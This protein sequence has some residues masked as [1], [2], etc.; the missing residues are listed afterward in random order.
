MESCIYLVVYIHFN[1]IYRYL[2]TE[3]LTCVLF[4]P[5]VHHFIWSMHCVLL[6]TMGIV[7]TLANHM[8]PKWDNKEFCCNLLLL[9]WHGT[10][11]INQFRFQVYRIQLNKLITLDIEGHDVITVNNDRVEIDAIDGWSSATYPGIIVFVLDPPL[12]NRLNSSP[13]WT[14]WP[15]FH[16][17]LFQMHFHEW[18]ISYFHSNLFFTFQLTISQHCRLFGAKPLPEQIP[19]EFSDAHMRHYGEMSYSMDRTSIGETLVLVILNLQPTIKIFCAMPERK[20]LP[21]VTEFRNC[22][23]KTAHWMI[24]FD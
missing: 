14:K 13:P 4:S 8:W 18:K 17:R 9:M 19:A 5:L 21:R 20:T 6:Y 11:M 2:S 3:V 10:R 15:P 24:I 22:T 1:D 23:S 16:R 7:L 12:S